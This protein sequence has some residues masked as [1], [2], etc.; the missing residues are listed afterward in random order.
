MLD[1]TACINASNEWTESSVYYQVGQ[2][3]RLQ[4]F[5]FRFRSTYDFSFDFMAPTPSA[6][7]VL[8]H[9]SLF[10]LRKPRSSLIL[11]GG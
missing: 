3:M 10:T 4:R 6:M 7:T 1:V 5:W 2:G 9:Y 8:T 11:N